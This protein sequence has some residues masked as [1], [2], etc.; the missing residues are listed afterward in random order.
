[1]RKSQKIGW[2]FLIFGLLIIPVS[3]VFFGREAFFIAT[4]FGLMA[5]VFGGFQLLLNKPLT[6]TVAV[7]KARKANRRR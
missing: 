5:A 2:G 7:P 1:M 3:Y 4:S 6:S